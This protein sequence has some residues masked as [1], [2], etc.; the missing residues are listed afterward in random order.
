M[1]RTDTPAFQAV[2]HKEINSP[3]A[4]PF[5]RTQLKISS[6]GI[7]SREQYAE[8]VGSVHAAKFHPRL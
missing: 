6:A 4:L 2:T 1:C 3:L 8:S 5:P 7:A